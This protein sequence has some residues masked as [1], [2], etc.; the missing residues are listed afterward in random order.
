MDVVRADSILLIQSQ[1]LMAN[2][3]GSMTEDSAINELGEI[4]GRTKRS[5]AP[6]GQV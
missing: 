6:A 1:S 3:T 5:E 4:L 2:L